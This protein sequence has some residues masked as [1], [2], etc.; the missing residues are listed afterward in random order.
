MPRTDYKAIHDAIK[1]KIEEYDFQYQ[2]ADEWFNLE[3]SD[4]IPQGLP[5]KAFNVQFGNQEEPKHLHDAITT[6]TQVVVEFILDAVK[7]NYLKDVGF[8]QEAVEDLKS[9]TVSGNDMTVVPPQGHGH[10]RFNR[11]FV[12]GDKVIL[13]FDQIFMDIR[14][15]KEG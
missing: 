6:S 8:C 14:T 2:F 3:V 1:A 4:E 11:V 10:E 15:F 9:L 12:V 5:G 13:T 7:D